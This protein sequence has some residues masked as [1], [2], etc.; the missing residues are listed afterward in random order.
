MSRG[1][2]TP[3]FVG[4][5][6]ASARAS[7][8]AQGSS[9]KANSRCEVLLRRAIWGRGLRY[10][11]HHP[12][13][14]GRPDIVF[15]R[16]RVVVF[17]DGDFWHGRNLQQRLER[18]AEGHNARYWVAKV[19][20]N[21]AR[22]ERQTRELIAGGWLVLRFWETDI[23]RSP[24]EVARGVVDAVRLRSPRAGGVRA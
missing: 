16:A 4:L 8:S 13:L 1:R 9:V 18:L 22:D 10:R 23:L 12:D 15:P 7:R 6:P 20:T 24:D 3:S 17:C 19:R 14:V 2:S 21:V 11:L 5:E